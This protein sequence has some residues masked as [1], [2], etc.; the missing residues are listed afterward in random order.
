MMVME[1]MMVIVRVMER[2]MVTV[3]VTLLTRWYHH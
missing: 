2:M 1:R 3:V